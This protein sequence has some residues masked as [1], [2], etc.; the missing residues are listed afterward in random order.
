VEAK[1]AGPFTDPGS[2]VAVK[3]GCGLLSAADGAIGM[4]AF[5][6]VPSLVG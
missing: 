6:G 1:L 2:G 3:V 4:L 5:A